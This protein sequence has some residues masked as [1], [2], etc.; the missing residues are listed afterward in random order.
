M[1]LSVVV[2]VWG[3]RSGAKS[4][5]N[6]WRYMRK[7]NEYQFPSAF[8]TRWVHRRI[9]SSLLYGQD[10]ILFVHVL[11]A[12]SMESSQQSVSGRSSVVR[13]FSWTAL[14]STEASTAPVRYD[15]MLVVTGTDRISILTLHRNA[16]MCPH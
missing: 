9:P 1:R 15:R 8:D 13:F 11:V 7:W 12:L 10:W 14:D 16:T 4:K 5:K 2:A 3:R 6:N